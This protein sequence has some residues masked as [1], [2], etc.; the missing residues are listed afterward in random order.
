MQIDL[1]YSVHKTEEITLTEIKEN[2]GKN[3]ANVEKT[4]AMR[5]IDSTLLLKDCSQR[6]PMTTIKKL[7][8][9][10]NFPRF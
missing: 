1:S 2:C 5:W 4:R 9:L 8:Q 3:E 6:L 7:I 10:L